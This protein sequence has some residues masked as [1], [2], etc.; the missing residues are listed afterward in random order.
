M[1]QSI[2]IQIINVFYFHVSIEKYVNKYSKNEREKR[3]AGQGSTP[4]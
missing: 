4:L 1:F 3:K 2:I